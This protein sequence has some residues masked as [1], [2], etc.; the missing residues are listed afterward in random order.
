[1]SKR[2]LIVNDEMVVGGVARVLNNL[3]TTLV[4]TTDYEIDLLVL[5]KHGEMLKGVP[6]EVR[7]LEGSKFFSVIDLPLGQ[8]IKSK[9]LALIARKLYLVFL[10]KAGMIGNKVKRERKKMKLDS[11]DVEIA[12]KEGFCTIFVA[13]G[14]SKKKVNWVHLDYKVQNF[15]SNYMPL[16]K[17]TL[18]LMDEQVAVSKVAAASYQEVFELS[19]PVKV[20]HNII[21]EDLIKQK[22]NV[23]IDE[24]RSTFFKQEALTFIS[25]GRLVDQKGYDRL[26]EIHH[27]LI[28]EGLLHHIMIIGGGEDE[29]VLK[30]KIKAYQVEETF[31]LIGYRENPFPYFKL[32]DCFLLPSRYEGL[33]TVV[34]ESLLCLTP[35]L[36]TKV[37]GIEEQL[38]NNEYGI[39]VDNNENSFYEGM[40]DLIKH[41]EQLNVM[42]AHL[43]TYHYHNNQIVE[44]IKEI[45]EE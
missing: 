35:V 15:S 31:K 19:N 11:Y 25:V 32:A 10:M 23:E 29:T 17:K 40:K 36:A 30:Q 4:K 9:N 20:I 13:N 14:N 8:L 33:P 21:Q 42:K 41:P 39:V 16:L 2:I 28:Q 44:Q 12:F 45:V 26:L 1:M 18:S 27:R 24:T 37:A 5:H 22:Y 34:F 3:L 38:K 7:V 6:K 43:L